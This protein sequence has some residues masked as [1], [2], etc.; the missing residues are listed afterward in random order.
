MTASPLKAGMLSVGIDVCFVPDSDI[1]EHTSRVIQLPVG[2][3]PR[4]TPDDVM[5]LTPAQAR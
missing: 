5:R 3:R 1:T 4:H 2:L